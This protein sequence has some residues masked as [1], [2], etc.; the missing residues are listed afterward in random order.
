M[1]ARDLMQLSNPGAFG[2]AL[3][4][5][6]QLYWLRKATRALDQGKPMLASAYLHIADHHGLYSH[7]E[8][9]RA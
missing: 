5:L 6:R 8:W 7:R 2:R 9:P 4:R 3:R 1:P